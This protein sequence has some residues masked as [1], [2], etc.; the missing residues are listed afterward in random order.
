MI[1]RASRF[2]SQAPITHVAGRDAVV[3]AC[4]HADRLAAWLQS[5]ASI[6]GT[7]STRTVSPDAISPRV[8]GDGSVHG[9]ASGNLEAA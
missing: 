1:G 8:L 7:A 5:D 3:V 4:E 6:A 2:R 9:R